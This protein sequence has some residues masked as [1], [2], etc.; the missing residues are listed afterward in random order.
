MSRSYTAIDLSL[1]PPPAII[2]TLDYETVLESLVVDYRARYPDFSALLESEPVVKLLE[3]VAYL[4]VLTRQRVNDG[5]RAVMLAYATGSDLDNLGGLFN[6]VRLAG[7]ADTAFRRRVLLSLEGFSTAGPDGAYLFHALSASNAV[8]DA[9]VS[10]PS[11][12]VVRVAVLSVDGDGAPTADALAAVA[13][14]LNGED[15]RPL[16]DTVQ[17]VPARIRRYALTAHLEIQNG[18]A[19][20]VVVE[21][22]QR[23]LD[24]YIKA[25]HVLGGRV[26]T[27][28]LAAAVH[29]A[30]VWRVTLIEPAADIIADGDEAPYCI[31]I[32]LTHQVVA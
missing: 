14:V 27:S 28:G 2:E 19:A 22:A 32:T 26:T 17:V 10:S 5:A 3:V 4:A 21:T 15:V 30:G 11:P 6:V 25:A 12:G 23:Q 13:A 1:L 8:R 9:S 20:S 24:A 29:P 18:P 7:E 31:A 16:T